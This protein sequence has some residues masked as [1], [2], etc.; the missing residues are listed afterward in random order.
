M[1]WGEAVAGQQQ[2]VLDPVSG[3]CHQRV[4]RHPE[5]THLHRRHP[6]PRRHQLRAHCSGWVGHLLKSTYHNCTVLLLCDIHEPRT[7]TVKPRVYKA[8]LLIKK[9]T[10][11]SDYTLKQT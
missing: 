10:N 1:E 8:P 9:K 4:H 6:P 5:R 2:S 11:N 7:H 3:V